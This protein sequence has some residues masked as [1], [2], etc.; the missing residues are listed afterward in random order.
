MGGVV[1]EGV[2]VGGG[3]VAGGEVVGGVGEGVCVGEGDGLGG[4][5]VGWGDGLGGLV[6][7]GGGGAGAVVNTGAGALDWAG[8][9]ECFGAG[10][11]VA[12]FAGDEW[13]LGAGTGVGVLTGAT[14]AG[15]VGLA[16][17]PP[18][19][20]GDGPPDSSA[21]AASP[22]PSTTIA[23]RARVRSSLPRNSGPRGRRLQL[24]K[25]AA[26]T[27]ATRLCSGIRD[28]RAARLNSRRSRHRASGRSNSPRL[29]GLGVER[30]RRRRARH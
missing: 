30:R 13:L 14:A 3:E 15:V 1:S 11:E 12:C 2:G 26:T 22:P 4:W 25:G 17:A 18:S 23:I 8:L 16:T 21:R 19:G 28:S 7:G 5:V 10:L 6:C 9:V 24:L 29:G 20:D 27:A